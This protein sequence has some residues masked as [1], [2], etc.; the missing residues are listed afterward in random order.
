VRG[1]A[2]TDKRARGVSDRGGERNDRAGLAQEDLGADR[3]ARA[4]GHACTKCYPRSEPFDLNRTEGIKPGGNRRLRG[5]E[6]FDLNWTE[7]IRPGG[8][9]RLRG[10]ESFDLNRMEGIRP[11]GN[12]R[13]W[14]VPLLSTAV[15][16]PELRLAR[17]KVAPG[18]PKLGREGEGTTAN[19]M[20]GKRP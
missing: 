17:A 16:S 20:A 5:F 9:K 7:G 4:S 19:S 11:G 2:S 8:N 14:A 1:R 3:Q 10:S 18:S 12:K 15:R 13:L 6:P